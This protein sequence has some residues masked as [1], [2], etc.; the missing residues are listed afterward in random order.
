MTP[1][2]LK[3]INEAKAKAEK[4]KKDAPQNAAAARRKAE[5]KLEYV[6]SKP[7]ENPLDAIEYT[8]N[9]ET[10]AKAELEI[11]AKGP[12]SIDQ[13]RKAIAQNND[14]EFWFQVVFAS[15]EQKEAVLKALKLF[16]Y[17]DKWIYG[18]EFAKVLGVDCPPAEFEPLRPRVD[19]RLLMLT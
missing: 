4:A 1:E 17:G 13:Q 7:K 9:C 10:D 14:T 8:G 18:E 5:K 2:Q 12:N 19:K 15:R 16:E 11:I 6:K 3:K